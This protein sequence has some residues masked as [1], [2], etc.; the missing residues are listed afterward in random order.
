MKCELVC[1]A[2]SQGV[3]PV[4]LEAGRG[5]GVGVRERE[6]EEALFLHSEIILDL[7]PINFV[8]FLLKNISCAPVIENTCF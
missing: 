4:S 1:I 5:E 6:S 7:K 8:V 3:F 2:V